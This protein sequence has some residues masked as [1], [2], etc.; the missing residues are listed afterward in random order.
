MNPT[1]AM[2][3]ITLHP[4]KKSFKTL[5]LLSILVLIACS[6]CNP[7]GT[8]YYLFKGIW[9]KKLKK[10][11]RIS[12][13]I[14]SQATSTFQGVGFA[15]EYLDTSDEAY[16]QDF[17]EDMRNN[18]SAVDQV[19]VTSTDAEFEVN[20][21]SIHLSEKHRMEW[22]EGEEFDMAELEV[23]VKYTLTHVPSGERMDD[24]Q[25]S[26]SEKDDLKTLEPEGEPAYC[27]KRLRSLGFGNLMDRVADK[28]VSKVTN[29]IVKFRK[30]NS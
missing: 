19:V 1:K 20:I 15:E 7:G 23:D 21:T 14:Q 8:G 30:E 2:Q 11:A 5:S 16:T 6:S 25:A 26:V 3:R 13:D 24:G 12:F 28:T 18:L 17:E 22:C 27:K 4:M 29:R 9:N 10:E